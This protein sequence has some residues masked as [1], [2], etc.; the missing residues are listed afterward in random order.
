MMTTTLLTTTELNTLFHHYS[1]DELVASEKNG[2]AFA[3]D[4]YNLRAAN[5]TEFVMRILKFQLPETV[6]SEVEMQHRLAEVGIGTP[7]YLTFDNGKHVG[8]NEELRF[9]LSER[10]VGEVPKTASL[11]LIRS[12]GATLAQFHDA[13]AGTEVLFSKMQWFQPK[14]VHEYL[15]KYDGELKPDITKLI[16]DGEQLFQT[17]LPQT[18]IHGD[19]WLGNVFAEGEEVTAV[20]D[21][22]TAEHNY[23]I[24]DLARTY[25]SMRLETVY[26]REEVIDML[27]SGYDEVATKPLTQEEKNNFGLA[28]SYT[29]G[30][31]ALWHDLNGT[32]YAGNYLGFGEEK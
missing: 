4:A 5:G 32:K 24:I 23:R 2:D 3:N 17:D 7:H 30:V 8:E 6:E 22:E 13:L 10:I 31:C 21:M 14:N 12:F 27:F 11:D 26:T 1:P 18:L 25:L 16:T 9:T 15:E 29:A 28:I 20:F 19:L